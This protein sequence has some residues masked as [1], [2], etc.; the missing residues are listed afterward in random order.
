MS[1]KPRGVIPEYLREGAEPEYRRLN[2]QPADG[3][4]MPQATPKRV[5]PKQTPASS[6]PQRSRRLNVHVGS[7]EDH[8]WMDDRVAGPRE[9]VDNNDFVDV[10]ALQG[11]N[12][13]EEQQWEQEMQNETP[14]T[15]DE[16]Q[17]LSLDTG[18]FGIY[19]KGVFVG[20]TRSTVEVKEFVEHI[21]LKKGVELDDVVVYKRVSL[22]FGILVDA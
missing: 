9:Y 4:K 11:H 20:K 15:A 19:V 18:E 5:P 3:L 13:L 21:V 7:H 1:N 6:T 16:E 8:S 12:P 22:D 14:E 2:I 10:D 17:S